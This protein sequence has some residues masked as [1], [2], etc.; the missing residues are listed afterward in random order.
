MT[1]TITCRRCGYHN[2]SG[3][4][5]CS[6]C[7]YRI[8]LSADVP[9]D[10][11]WYPKP[12]VAARVGSVLRML[13]MLAVLAGLG[14]LLWPVK[15]VGA[16]GSEE[17]AQRLE[18]KLQ[19]LR[20]AAGAGRRAAQ[21][22]TEAEVNACMARA[23]AGQGEGIRSP[24]GLRIRGVRMGFTPGHLTVVVLANWGVLP[25]SYELDCAPEA[26]PGGFRANVRLARWGHLPLPG[27]AA[28]WMAERVG[29]VFAG[30]AEERALL[31]RL[32][33]FEVGTGR[34]G[35]VTAGEQ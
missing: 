25:L 11:S 23:V 16:V 14:L 9:V 21:I 6:R 3:H 26:G 7:G 1:A 12:S 13:V 22:V 34:V 28:T 31:A 17:D 33:R 27:P 30:M 5:F 20:A 32:D 8:Q 29:R 4:V 24:V 15:P 2:E 10:Y 35:L 18:Q 19:V